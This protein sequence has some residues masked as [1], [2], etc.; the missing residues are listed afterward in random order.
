MDEKLHEFW[1][2][3]NLAT[4]LL[5]IICQIDDVCYTK[6]VIKGDLI[7]FMRIAELD[8]ILLDKEN[9]F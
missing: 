8:C 6:E 5:S 1:H 3:V 7:E 2:R 9:Y 4:E